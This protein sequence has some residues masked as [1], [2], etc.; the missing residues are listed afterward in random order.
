MSDAPLWT[1]AKAAKATAG[2]A[3]GDWSASGVSIDSRSLAPGDLF[4]ALAG[5]NFDGHDFVVGALESGAAAAMIHRRPSGL[6]QNAPLL[7][8]GD[9]LAALAA[10]GK[11]ARARSEAT[12]VGITGSA[13]KTGTKE[14]MRACLGKIA[15]C[16]AN[17]SSLNN[18]WGVPLSL[19]RF[20]SDERY[21]VFEMGMNHAG[22]IAELTRMV[23]P[24]LAV[25]TNIGIAHIEFFS[26]RA[27]IADA[28][29]E[30]FQGLDG[31]KIAVLP[32]DCDYF[33][34]LQT[35]ARE[36]GAKRI[37]TFG[38]HSESDIRLG[39]AA[40]SA[41]GSLVTASALGR[42]IAYPLPLPGEHWVSNSLAV[43]AALVALDVDLETAVMGF[44][45]LKAMKGRGARKRIPLAAGGT[46]LMIDDS[47]N[48]NPISVAAAL[49]VLGR[50]EGGRRIAVLGD[51]LELGDDASRYH[52]ELT[53]PI[54]EAGLDLVFTCGTEMAALQE[55]LPEGLRGAH[56]ASS[57]ELAPQV[58]A[59]LLPGDLVLVKGSLGSRMALIVDAI[60]GLAGPAADSAMGG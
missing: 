55:A 34:R 48:A 59:A 60:E 44:A 18:H 23:R 35:A 58:A 43:V 46:L 49:A 9:T 14:A 17:A 31:P 28:K 39:D 41:E 56:A 3:Q 19:S 8:V 7:E 29:A 53:D 4:V 21:G 57:A 38:R 13:G 22:E 1:A 10:L 11:A 30:I 27:G 20:A 36:C 25:I 16:Y 5:P 45:E 6:P 15:S 52:R 24:H 26:S 2:L 51:M 12:I 50:L 42:R 40:L 37:L 47:Y 54:E 33:D 32:R